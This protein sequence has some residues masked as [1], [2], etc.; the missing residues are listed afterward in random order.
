MHDLF[1]VSRIHYDMAGYRIAHPPMG[2][3]DSFW[4]FL[5]V[6]RHHRRIHHLHDAGNR[7]PHD[8]TE[9][10]HHHRGI[11]ILRDRRN[12]PAVRHWTARSTRADS[13][14]RTCPDIGGNDSLLYTRHTNPSK[15]HAT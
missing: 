10:A 2:W 12:H 14:N 4:L 7:F 11:G 13:R 15:E 8:E 6:H 1:A 3:A 9:P 5:L